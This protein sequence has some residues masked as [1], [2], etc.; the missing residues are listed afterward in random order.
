[1]ME[2]F[3]GSDVFF[4]GISAYLHKHAYNNAETADLFNALQDATGGKL[5]VKDIMDTWTRQG[6][7]PVVNVK[8]SG[9]KFILTQ[10]R[11]LDDQDAKSD[12]SQSEY[13]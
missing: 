1:M 9:N 4:G 5:K 12:P 8:K 11:F 6:G 2:N 10:E 7:Y 13:G 3:F